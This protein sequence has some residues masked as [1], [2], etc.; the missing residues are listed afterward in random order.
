MLTS[1]LREELGK[2]VLEMGRNSLDK[3]GL[4]IM[5]LARHSSFHVFSVVRKVLRDEMPDKVLDQVFNMTRVLEASLNHTLIP[6]RMHLKFH[7]CCRSRFRW[8]LIPS[9]RG[10]YVTLARW[11]FKAYF[12]ETADLES[13]DARNAGVVRP[14]GIHRVCKSCCQIKRNQASGH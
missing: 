12:V 13:L 10:L 14:K 5:S 9:L 4:L 7:P 1:G 8:L 2:S 11:L 3:G 6:D